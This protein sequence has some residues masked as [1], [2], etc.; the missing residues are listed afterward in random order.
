MDKSKRM[1]LGV[2]KKTKPTKQNKKKF[3]KNVLDYLKSDSYMFAP[4]ISPP[5]SGYSD[6][7]MKEPIKGNKKRELK[8]DRN[9]MKSDTYMYAPLL[10]PP[11]G[12]FQ[13][14]RK[15]TDEVST[16]MLNLKESGKSTESANARAENQQRNDS[17]LERSDQ[18]SRHGERVKHMVYQHCR[19]TPDNM[20]FGPM[21]LVDKA[22]FVIL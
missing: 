11:S 17:C 14:R 3:L 16:T 7:K 4:L 5:L 6:T 2:Q 10:P 9:Y 20:A 13:S 12:Q 15:I 22:S 19:S 1:S 21:L 18:T 8:K